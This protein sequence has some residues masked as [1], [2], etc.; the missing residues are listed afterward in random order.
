MEFNIGITSYNR[1]ESTRRCLESVL[2]HRGEGQAV[3]VVDNGSS[4]GSREYL[5]K[6]RQAGRIDHLHLFRRNMGVACAANQA[7]GA[8]E[9]DFFVKLDNDM[10]VLDKHWLEP[11]RELAGDPSVGAAAYDVYNTET[12]L[13][14]LPSGR[15]A[16]VATFCGGSCIMIRREVHDLLGFWCEDYGLYG[17]EDSDFGGRV[18]LAKL[19]NAYV[20]CAGRVR[21]EHSAYKAGEDQVFKPRKARRKGIF[22][23]HFNMNLYSK[24]IRSLYVRRKY[25]AREKD[26]FIV[27]GP[28]PEYVQ[29]LE[30]LQEAFK[31]FVKNTEKAIDDYIGEQQ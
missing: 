20:D 6:L 9:A 3:T 28:D 30:N 25:L 7:W 8:C 27:H 24:D 23:L 19:V 26:G 16:R 13:A 15:F 22:T 11:L 14:L 21:H 2:E 4:D 29:G 31:V 18:V 12:R 1:L 17:E 10:V 5:L